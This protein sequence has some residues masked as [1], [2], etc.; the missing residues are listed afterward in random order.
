M[1][2]YGAEWENAILGN[3]RTS[4]CA[5]V[6]NP[7]S[8]NPS[9]SATDTNVPQGIIQTIDWMSA[10]AKE[11]GVVFDQGTDLPSR[12]TRFVQ[13]EGGFSSKTGATY[14]GF[15]AFR[16]PEN[17]VIATAYQP[18]YANPHPMISYV[19]ALGF[20]YRTGGNSSGA[21]AAQFNISYINLPRDFRNKITQVGNPSAKVF[22]ADGG[23]W[24]NGSGGVTTTLTLQTTSPGG[25]DA[26]YGPWEGWQNARSYCYQSA[27]IDGRPQAMRHGTTRRKG[28]PYAS[29]SMNMG[30]FDGH[31]ENMN[32]LQASNPDYWVPMGTMIPASEANT[33]GP[34]YTEVTTRYWPGNQ[35]FIAR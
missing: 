6:T 30:F 2:S 19:E 8:D 31:V 16:C 7:S 22:I 35:A 28:A 12:A 21:G 14:S 9:F 24:W 33:S 15:K 13:L 20:Q 27:A 26:D 32:G 25:M 34:G 17:D 10:T 11:M 18:S 5:I 3:G 23:R 1:N 4:N 29:M